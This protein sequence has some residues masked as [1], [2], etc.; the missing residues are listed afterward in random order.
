MFPAV[1]ASY[2]A[3]ALSY[4]SVAASGAAA[5]GDHVADDVLLSDRAGPAP[6]I[7]AANAA[8]CFHVAAGFHVFSQPC[9]SGFEAWFEK[10][11]KWWWRKSGGGGP[12]FSS[13]TSSS[14]DPKA[15]PS[16]P[17]TTA[18]AAAA[19][20]AAPAAT[21]PT[22]STHLPPHSAVAARFFYVLLVAAAAAALPFFSVCMALVGALAFAPATFVLPPAFAFFSRSPAM[23]RDKRKRALH[24]AMALSFGVLSLACSVSAARGLVV[25]LQSRLRGLAV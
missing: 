1:K 8:V 15:A 6:L 4:F 11:Q 13:L 14:G 9:Y 22:T 5:F 23:R 3:V 21:V 18:E 10:K 16:L 17:R 25:A 7:A 12:P 2:L 19:A 20:A 24:G